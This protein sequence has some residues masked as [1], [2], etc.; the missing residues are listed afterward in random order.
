MRSRFSFNKR[1]SER[2]WTDPALLQRGLSTLHAAVF[3]QPAARDVHGDGHVDVL[4]AKADLLPEAQDLALLGNDPC[5]ER[6]WSTRSR[7]DC[8][9]KKFPLAVALSETDDGHSR[10]PDESISTA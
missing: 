5:D 9:E 2:A 10:E 3:A 1:L 8:A 4:W 6:A 7:I